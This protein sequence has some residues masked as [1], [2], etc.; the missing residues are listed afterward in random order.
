MRRRLLVLGLALVLLSGCDSSGDRVLVGK[1]LYDT[2]VVPPERYDVVVFKYPAAPVE[3]GTPKNYIKRLLGLPGELIAIFFGQLFSFQHTGP[4]APEGISEDEW[5]KLTSVFR[6]DLEVDRDRMDGIKRSEGV[7]EEEWQKLPENAK[8]DQLVLW[9][10]MPKDSEVA[11]K[12]WNISKER[13]SKGQKGLFQILRKPPPQMLALS[14]I[15]YDNDHQAKD[16]VGIIPERWA[17]EGAWVVDNANG[18]K[19]TS[20]PKT[21]DRLA[22]RHILRPGKDEWPA[23]NDPDRASK[24]EEIRRRQH[25]PQLIRDTLGYNTY[26]PHNGGQPRA[27]NW[28]GDLMLT[29]KLSVLEP[30]GEFWMELSKGVDRFQARFDLA[31]GQCSLYRLSQHQAKAGQENGQAKQVPEW[32]LLGTTTTPTRIKAKGDYQIRFANY[33]QRLTV[34]VDRELPFED[35]KEYPPPVENGP[36]TADAN[37]NNDLHPAS[38]ISFGASVEVH[39]LKLWRDTYYTDNDASVSV[40][41]DDWKYPSKWDSLRH[42]NVRTYFVFPNHYL[43]LGDNSPESSDSRFWG[44]VPQRLML[45]RALLVY[46]PFDRAGMI[47]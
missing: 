25:L 24:I 5:R 45:G 19:V 40:Y 46:F 41:G 8:L 7:N 1:F 14:R 33:D 37:V 15:V 43:C 23:K 2:N 16:L 42:P 9:R 36:D 4:G 26:E 30:K 44:L 39:N 10:Y 31:S 11:Q 21:E 18:F 28:V 29:C 17:P 22:Y 6:K 38:I 20:S 34:W 47:K 32:Q 13:E 12:L 27:D 35:G 3:K